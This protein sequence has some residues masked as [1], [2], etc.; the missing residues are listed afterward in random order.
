MTT[1]DEYVEII[2]KIARENDLGLTDNVD[3]IARFRART[4]MPM[5]KCPC[6]PNATDRGCI[7]KKCWDEIK[8]DGVCHCNLFRRAN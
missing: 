4:Q 1:I 7:G 5:E 3:N 2:E 6:E 8:K